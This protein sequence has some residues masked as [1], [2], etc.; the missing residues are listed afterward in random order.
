M[1]NYN[2]YFLYQWGTPEFLLNVRKLGEVV[3]YQWSYTGNKQKTVKII[4]NYTISLRIH[5]NKKIEIPLH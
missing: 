5:R 3:L 2:G 1:Q 4:E